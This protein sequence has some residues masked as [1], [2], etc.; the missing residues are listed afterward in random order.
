MAPGQTAGMRALPTLSAVLALALAG[1]VHAAPTACQPGGRTMLTA[2]LLLGGKMGRRV[3]TRQAWRRFLDQ[4]VTPRF[5]D[6]FTVFDAAG[7][8]RD[9]VRGTIVREPSRVLLIA[10]PDTP[11]NRKRLRLVAEAYKR[12]FKQQSVG[13]ILRP[14]CVSF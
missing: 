9:R 8:W 13:T 4:E 14:G 12:R 2:E 1:S 5:P 3:I 7:Q 6:G 11:G 10:L